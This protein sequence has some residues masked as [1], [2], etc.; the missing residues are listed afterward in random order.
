M[1]EKSQQNPVVISIIGKTFL[2]PL[3]YKWLYH[4]V[5]DI[6]SPSLK[7]TTETYQGGYSLVLSCAEGLLP[8][9]SMCA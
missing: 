2:I 3:S 1:L 7:S 8:T 5:T 4:G 9:V 6:A